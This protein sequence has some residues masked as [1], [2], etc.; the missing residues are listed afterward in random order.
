MCELSRFKN[1]FKLHYIFKINDGHSTRGTTHE[2]A[3]VGR[4]DHNVQCF[5]K[6]R[7][8]LRGF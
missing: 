7:A 6:Q 5:F 4:F 3:T 1:E 8:S 2:W